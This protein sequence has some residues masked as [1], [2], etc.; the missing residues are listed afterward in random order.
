VVPSLRRTF[1]GITVS[2]VMELARALPPDAAPAAVE[3]R[4]L[5]KAVLTVAKEV[6][7]FGTT[8]DVLPLVEV[9]GQTIGEGRP[10]PWSR[11]FLEL[12]QRDME[13]GSEVLTPLG[14]KR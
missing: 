7:V 9:D 2:R 12:L 14:K 13:P 5:H 4:P 3:H 10:G 6:L 1:P 8:L 11:C